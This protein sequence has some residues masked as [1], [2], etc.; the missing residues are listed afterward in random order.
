MK[1][2]RAAIQRAW[3][4]ELGREVSIAEARRE[5]LNMQHR[6]EGFTFYCHDP[7]C[8]HSN[9]RV[10][11]SGVNYR[12][13]AEESDKYRKAHFRAHPMHPHDDACD[14]V[15]GELEVSQQNEDEEVVSTKTARRKTTDL[16]TVFD[17]RLRPATSGTGTQALHS[18]AALDS[19]ADRAH[20]RS[21]GPNDSGAPGEIR[22]S[23]LDEL[24]DSYLEAK[25]T[26]TNQEFDELELKI[27]GH[28]EIGYRDYFQWIGRTNCSGVTYGG[29][30]NI[31][32]YNEGFCL[33]FF[34]KF[35]NRPVQLYV[36]AA[37]LLKYRYWRH[38]RSTIDAAKANPDGC[39]I[40]VFALGRLEYSD[41]H[42]S[43]NLVVGDLSHLTLIL[44]LKTPRDATLL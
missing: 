31:K 14:W 40:Q 44:K 30:K 42:K 11:V 35:K 8:R 32:D 41:T 19:G 3:C 17:P 4:V 43:W 1:T 27:I 20:T 39:Y 10:L 38:L 21:N 22:T 15:T 13:P 5:Y 9:P 33:Y 34:D 29:I 24:V 36:S 23:D 6:P 12:K 25:S 26:H 28:G 18:A 37:Q 7:A 16:V 2:V